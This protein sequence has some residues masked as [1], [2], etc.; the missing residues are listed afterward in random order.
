MTIINNPVI[1]LIN[2]QDFDNHD[3]CVFNADCNKTL[4]LLL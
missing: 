3:R 4:A 1:R 2:H